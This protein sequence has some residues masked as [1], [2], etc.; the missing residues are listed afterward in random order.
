MGKIYTRIPENLTRTY[1]YK[2]KQDE[3]ASWG[4]QLS[5]IVQW[6][7]R[8]IDTIHNN[9]STQLQPIMITDVSQHKFDNHQ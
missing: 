9:L 2:P 4:I 5:Y 8:D 7:V 6:V 3:L 1:H